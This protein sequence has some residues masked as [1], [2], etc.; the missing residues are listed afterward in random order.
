MSPTHGGWCTPTSR[1]RTSRAWRRRAV[2]ALGSEIPRQAP[3][4]RRATTRRIKEQ[5]DLVARQSPDWGAAGCPQARARHSGHD[6]RDDAGTRELG[7][8][9]C[10]SIPV[11]DPSLQES[12]GVSVPERTHPALA[13]PTQLG[14]GPFPLS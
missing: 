5:I 6:G 10:E 4:V 12:Q 1:R 9:L 13:A 14:E 8:E 3:E 7:H 2:A 11:S